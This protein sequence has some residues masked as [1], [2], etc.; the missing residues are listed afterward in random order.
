M[1]GEKYPAGQE[2]SYSPWMASFILETFLPFLRSRGVAEEHLHTI[3]V[4]NPRHV[5]T[6]VEPEPGAVLA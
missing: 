1:E 6:L 5:P 4:E 3:T 2:P